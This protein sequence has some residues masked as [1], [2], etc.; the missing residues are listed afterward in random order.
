MTT[1]TLRKLPGGCYAITLCLPPD[2]AAFAQV[3]CLARGFATPDGF[4]SCVLNTAM[5][6]EMEAEPPP[7]PVGFDDRD[8]DIPF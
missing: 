7:C 1:P 8:D 3:E 5:F 2:I 4:L 6:A